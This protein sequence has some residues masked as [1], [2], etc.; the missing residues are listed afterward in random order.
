MITYKVAFILSHPIQYFSPLFRE[1]AK[2]PQIDLMVYYCSDETIKTGKDV[3]FGVEVKW[4]IP[5]LDGYKYKFLKNHSPLATIFKPPLG[6]INLGIMR[7]IK[8]NRYDAII[9][10]GWNY[11]TYLLAYMTAILNR[12]PI[13]IRA[14]SP[15]S[16]ELIKPKW[17]IFIKKI[18]LGGLFKHVASFLAIGT[19]NKQ[20]YKFHNV[21]DNRIFHTPYAVENGRFI[22]SYDELILLKD[23]LKK[24]LGIPPD[25]IVI[26]FSGKLIGRKRPMD[27]LLAY[28][29]ANSENKALV[30]LGDGYLRKSLEEFVKEEKLKNVYFFGFKNQIEIPKHYIIAD[31]FVLPS[32]VENWGLVVNEAMCFR[33]P[34]IVSDI[35]GCARDLVKSG[36][37]GFIYPV[38]DVDKLSEYLLKLLHNPELRRNLGKRSFEIVNKWSYEE[39]VRGI[40]SAL[41][42]TK[43]HS[44]GMKE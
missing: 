4:D 24:E 28:K 22:E 38:G 10:H 33:L 23:E 37:N 27:L 6:L 5:L 42:Y 43:K 3:E 40:V 15:L 17:K 12:I 36:E 29:K 39:D 16:Q 11:I 8:K 25:K 44:E 7:E 26:L 18:L 35:V 13:F 14:E 2:H 30:Y 41:E 1:I 31:I 32:I 19:E 21:T 34:V 9:V 20:F